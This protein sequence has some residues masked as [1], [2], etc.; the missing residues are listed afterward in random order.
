M[1][2]FLYM[3][4]DDRAQ[5]ISAPFAC[6]NDEVAKRNFLFGCFGAGTPP[7]DCSL[8]N[9]GEYDDD[10]NN[11]GVISPSGFRALRVPVSVEEIEHIRSK[12]L[13]IGSVETPLE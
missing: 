3:I 2:G 7:S 5:T 8:Y 10:Y 11:F 12:F 4:G 9:V 6:P 1:K 13:E